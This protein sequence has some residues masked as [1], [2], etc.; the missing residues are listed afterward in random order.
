MEL[1]T[2]FWEDYYRKNPIEA[3]R[4]GDGKEVKFATGDPLI[5]KWEE[6]LARGIEPDLTEGLS[7]EAREK[8]KSARRRLEGH[9]D[10]VKQAEVTIG[11]GF[12][13]SYGD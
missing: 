8:E 4:V 9:A 11:D 12:A 6:E 3:K 2:L 5:D 13:D 10:V 1:L 7:H